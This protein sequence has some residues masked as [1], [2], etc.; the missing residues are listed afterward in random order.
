M[1]DQHPLTDE[2]IS[3][4]F[5]PHYDSMGCED[6]EE[7]CVGFDN[8]DLRAAADWQLRKSISW[9]HQHLTTEMSPKDRDFFLEDFREAMRPQQ[10]ENND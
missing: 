8:D 2:L 4:N 3:K 7:I 5:S 9:L 10:Q 6:C 1:T